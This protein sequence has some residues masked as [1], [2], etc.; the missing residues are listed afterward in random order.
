MAWATIHRPH[1]VSDEHD[2][3]AHLMIDHGAAPHGLDDIIDFEQL[4]NEHRRSHDEDFRPS[5]RSA[6]AKHCRT[7]RCEAVR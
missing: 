3:F 1:E 7:C 2:L 4:I 5:P 6:P